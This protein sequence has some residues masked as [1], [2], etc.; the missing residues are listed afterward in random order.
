MI[1]LYPCALRSVLLHTLAQR[2]RKALC[3]C[4]GSITRRVWRD[5]DLAVLGIPDRSAAMRV[6]EQRF[7]SQ[8]Y[9]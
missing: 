7:G 4:Q 3:K 5:V 2:Y 1:F 8:M 6:S 9:F